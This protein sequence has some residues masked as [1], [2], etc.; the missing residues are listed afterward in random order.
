MTRAPGQG[1]IACGYFVTNVLTDAGFNIPGIKWAQSA[2]EVFILKLAKKEIARF[3]NKPV[4]DVEA[5]LRK[6]GDGI[7]LVGLD[8]HAGFLIVN[9]N[10]IRF[11]HSNYYHREIGVMSQE[12]NSVNPLRDFNYRR[13]GKLLS[14][15]MMRSWIEGI[16]YK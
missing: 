10:S 16:A 5:W 2:S 8:S 9:D 12:I 3:S 4:E 15:E 13:V 7:Y 14:D 6:T 11:V 1:S